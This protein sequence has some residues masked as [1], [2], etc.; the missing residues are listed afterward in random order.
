MSSFRVE[1]LISILNAKI[2]VK[3]R[4]YIV[5]FS[6]H[7]PQNY[8]NDISGFSKALLLYV[9]AQSVRVFV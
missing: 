5:I 1:S 6:F 7:N 8:L 9:S 4:I 2:L 3:I